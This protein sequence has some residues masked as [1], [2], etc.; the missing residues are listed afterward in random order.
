MQTMPPPAPFVFDLQFFSDAED[1]GRTEDPTARQR[2]K[3]EGE[4]KFART[5]DLSGPVGILVVAVYLRYTLPDMVKALGDFTAAFLSGAFLVTDPSPRDLIF[6]ATVSVQ[7]MIRITLPVMLLAALFQVVS[8]ITQVGFQFNFSFIKFNPAALKPDFARVFNRLL[9]QRET[10]VE[11][12][13]S[14]GKILIVGCVGYYIFWE[15]YGLILETSRMG[16]SDALTRIGMVAYKILLWTSALLIVF[17]IP[18][19]LYQRHQYIDSLKMT[20]FQV[21]D[22]YRSMEGDPQVRQA[23]RRR[24]VEIV[25]RQMIKRVP[26]ADVVIT[27]PTHFAVALRYDQTEGD[28]PVCVAKGKDY[29]ALRIRDIAEKNDVPVVENPP[30]ARALYDAVDVDEAIPGRFFESVA[31]VLAYVYRLK[32]AAV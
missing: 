18:D 10:L 16:M 29:M 12:A 17:A 21:K 5:R 25:N 32:T 22:E 7:T 26:K 1:E 15:N 24:M 30:L 13:K 9:P 14:I 19:Y 2:G 11:L 23:L 31:E 3:A 20:K 27:N 8:E 4:G 6:I 28:A